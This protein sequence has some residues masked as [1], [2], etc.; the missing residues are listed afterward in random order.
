MV[1]RRGLGRN[2]ATVSRLRVSIT[3]SLDGYVAGPD[4]SEENPLGSGGQDLHKWS[5]R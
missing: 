2:Q 4:Q 3:M 1:R 5:T